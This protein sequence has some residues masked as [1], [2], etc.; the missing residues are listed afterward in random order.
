MRPNRPFLI[1]GT[2]QLYPIGENQRLRHFEFSPLYVGS[3][4]LFPAAGPD[5]VDIGGGYVETF[6]FD[7]ATPS[8]PDAEQYV[9][10][11]T[12]APIFLLSD[13]IGS[14][15]A[16]PG[17]ILGEFDKPEW[18]STFSHWPS[19]NIGQQPATTYSF[20]DGGSL[21]NLGIVPLLRR[22]YPI[23]LLFVNT[24]C[25]IGTEN[26]FTV[27]GISGDISRLFGFN[28]QNTLSN[29]E[30]TQFFPTSQ[31]KALADGLKAAKANGQ[32]TYFIDS[33]PII[34]PNF[35][36]IPS[37][38][39]NR[40]VTIV[41]FYNDINQEWQSKL[42]PSVQELLRSEEPTNY[43]ANFPHYKTV[44]QNNNLS[45]VP[46][47]MQLTAEQIN[48]LAHMSCYTVMSVA[49]ELRALDV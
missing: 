18:F 19:L 25:P 9:T 36:D 15:G 3:P 1:A 13:L 5:G 45:G 26:E 6:A 35:F 8:P 7:T 30:N 10:V 16:A 21:E 23:I 38:P 24:P 33:Y 40:D 22:Q 31:F 46:Q 32:A 29:N 27:D 17:I 28:P 4:Q 37:Y 42:S 20:V 44:G 43:L 49:D 47:L 14:S 48:L 39:D 34:Q 12:S 41:W 2:T 11:P